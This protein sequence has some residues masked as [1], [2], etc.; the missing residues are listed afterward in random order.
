M[1]IKISSVVLALA[2]SHTRFLYADIFF[3]AYPCRES[4]KGVLSLVGWPAYSRL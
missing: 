2:K 1:D 4:E 3:L